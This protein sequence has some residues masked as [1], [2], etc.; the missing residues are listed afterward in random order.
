MELEDAIDEYIYYCLV[1]GFINKK[2]IHKRQELKNV[3]LVLKDKRGITQ[4]ESIHLD[5][6]KAYS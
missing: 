1:K 6:L 2:L 5:D 4:L 3:K